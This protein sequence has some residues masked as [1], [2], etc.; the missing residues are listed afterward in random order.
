MKRV[1]MIHSMQGE[2]V[3][4]NPGQEYELDDDLAI[5]L[6]T[7]PA[8]GPRAE[9]VGW[10]PPQEALDAARAKADAEAAD[11][12]EMREGWRGSPPGAESMAMK[13]EDEEQG[14]QEGGGD[15]MK[16]EDL[17]AAGGTGTEPPEAP[18]TEPKAWSEMEEDE[19]RASLASVLDRDPSELADAGVYEDGAAWADVDGERYRFFGD[20][21]VTGWEKEEAP[22]QTLEQLLELSRAELNNLAVNA[23]V[24]G[25]EELLN[26]QLV[27]EAILKARLPGTA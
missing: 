8:D 23:G 6:V 15:G 11:E 22:T 24:E 3:A 10:E 12:A 4:L 7:E 9:P 2:D 17:G 27:A 14:D 26:K 13:T 5:A 21:T 20:G 25:A 16:R 1:K 19:L 18:E